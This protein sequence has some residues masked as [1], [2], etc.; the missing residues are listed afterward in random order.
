MCSFVGN[1][2]AH[3]I[4][5]KTIIIIFQIKFYFKLYLVTHIIY[6]ISLKVM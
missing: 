4:T 1:I 3:I 6:S 5:N 2:I